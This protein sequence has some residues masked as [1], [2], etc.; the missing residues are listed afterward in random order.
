MTDS[1]LSDLT[2]YLQAYQSE[3]LRWNQRINL[4]SRQ[5][6]AQVLQTL[7]R[8]CVGGVEALSAALAGA[9]WTAPA[10]YFDL[11]SGGGLPGVI[12]HRYFCARNPEVRTWLVEPREKRAWFL[13]R[14]AGLAGTPPWNVANGR[15]EDSPPLGS[16]AAADPPPVVVVSLKALHLTD[17]QVL[18]GLAA[19]LPELGSCRL[20][21]ARYYPADQ[22]LDDQL[23][24]HLLIPRPGEPAAAGPAALAAA[25]AQILTWGSTPDASLVLSRYS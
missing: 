8:Q 16:V 12:W 24:R 3:L 13:E 15:W 10:L 4:V 20:A 23:R 19:A 1:P 18:A 7:F 21:I 2:P 14:L 6:T 17:P 22:A 25:T 9:G 5:N 11:G